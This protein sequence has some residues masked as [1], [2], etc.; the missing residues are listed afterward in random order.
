MGTAKPSAVPG[1]RKALK[2]HYCTLLRDRPATT[3]I[4]VEK[5]VKLFWT[6][7]TPFYANHLVFFQYGHWLL[8]RIQLTF[9]SIRLVLIRGFVRLFWKKWKHRPWLNLLCPPKVGSFSESARMRSVFC[10]IGVKI[11]VIGRKIAVFV[12]RLN[13]YRK[14]L[15]SIRY[16]NVFVHFY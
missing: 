1:Q 6:T 2:G 7:F 11:K 16:Q 13:S 9:R 8:E 12:H 15:A 4:P 14:A 3:W 10:R 5:L